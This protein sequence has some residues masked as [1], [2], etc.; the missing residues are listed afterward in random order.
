MILASTLSE[1]LQRIENAAKAAG[2][3][4]PRLLAVSKLQ[5]SAAIAQLAADGQHAFGENYVQEAQA[6]ARELAGLGLEWH[7]I[8]HLQS[9]KAEA[10][11]TLFDWVQTVDRGKLVAAL[12]RFRPAGRPPL[13]VLVQVNVDDETSKHGCRPGEV[14]ALAAA[15]AAEP[16]LA[17]RGLMAI[18]TP[19][20]DIELRRPAFRRMRELFDGLAA[21]YPSVDT[22]SM[23]MSDDF[24]LAIGE[25]AT[26]VRIGTALFGARPP[27]T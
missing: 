3:P 14:D 13:N 24:A 6:K 5:P 19:H 1:T 18:P 20:A 21:R 15:I 17:L 12:A 2:R 11:A 23:G 4:V 26:M 22:L 16:G 25:G 9:N 27:K 8:G 7:L 10:A